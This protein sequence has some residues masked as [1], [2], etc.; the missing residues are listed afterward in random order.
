MAARAAPLSADPPDSTGLPRGRPAPPPLPPVP[1]FPALS[2][3]PGRH[4]GDG[5]PPPIVFNRTQPADTAPH[6]LIAYARDAAADTG[7]ASSGEDRTAASRTSSAEEQ[8]GTTAVVA[9]RAGD[10]VAARLTTGI[11]VAAGVPAVP[12]VAE[13][14]DGSIWLG[15]AAAEADGRVHIT[16]QTPRDAPPAPS[17]APA[18]AGTTARGV[19]L[20][21]ALDPD[22]LAAGLPARIVTRRRAAAAAAIGAVAQAAADYVQALSR[23]GQ[24]SIT[25]GAAQITVG[26]PAPGWTYAASRLADTLNP[27]APG[28]IQTLEVP[29]GARCVILITEAP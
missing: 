1:A 23:A 21:V 28:T 24:I 25:D 29:A 12:V 3:L 2:P 5:P 9:R 14:T 11:V 22:Q 16:F 15:H 4:T 20:G 26:G 10:R 27:Q 13:G 7:A 17:P 19:A 18:R 6:S 8:D